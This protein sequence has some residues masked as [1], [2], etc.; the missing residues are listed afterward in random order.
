MSRNFVLV[1]PL[2]DVKESSEFGEEGVTGETSGEGT[3]H[4]TS[5]DSVGGVKYLGGKPRGFPV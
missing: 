1:A 5:G 2:R 4:E 3:G